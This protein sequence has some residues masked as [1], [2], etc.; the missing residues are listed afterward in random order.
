MKYTIPTIQHTGTKLLAKMFGDM[1]W[2]SFT[3]DIGDREN[4]LFLGHLTVNSVDNIKKLKHPIIIPFRHPFL[5]YES[6]IR[7]NKN[8]PDL[9]ENIRLLVN[10]IDPLNPH[11][12]PI[13]VP[14]K[15]NY[16]DKLNRDLDID[17]ITDWGIENSKKATYNLSYRDIKPTN[18]ILALVDEIGPFLNRFY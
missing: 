6:W 10:E 16:L 2:A 5:I 18:D 12:V 8:I 4:V 7:R 3:E 9:I 1:H 15:Q 14:N 13:D 11:Y 17:L